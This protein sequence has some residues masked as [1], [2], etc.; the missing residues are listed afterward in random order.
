MMSPSSRI[1]MLNRSGKGQFTG[2]GASIPG[3]TCTD[4]ESVFVPWW[5]MITSS[6]LGSYPTYP[7]EWI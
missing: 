2:T 1:W 3:Y 6:K 5:L 4:S 7:N